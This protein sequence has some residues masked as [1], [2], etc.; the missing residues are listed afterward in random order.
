V[1][2][3]TLLLA[4]AACVFL[5]CAGPERTP[6]GSVRN[7]WKQMAAG[8]QDKVLR[9]QVYYRPGMTSEFIMAPQ[10][11]EWLHL[12]S[13]ATVYQGPERALVYYQVVFKKKGQERTTRYSTGTMAHLVDGRW[14][15]GRPVGALR[16]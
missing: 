4:L 9:T 8:D 14:K 1:K 6:E 15:V 3:P 12:D 13:V 2:H 7:F 5:C 11:I 16:K 10:N